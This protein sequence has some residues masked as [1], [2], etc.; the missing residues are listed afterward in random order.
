MGEEPPISGTAGS[1]TI[2]FSGCNLKCVFCQN[3]DVSRNVVGETISV[4]RLVEI[5]HELEEKG[6]HNINLVTPSHYVSKI[7]DAL[8]IYKPSIP[9]VYNTSGYDSLEAID[10]LAGLVDIYLTDLKYC[11]ST[12]SN[13]YSSAGDYFDVATAA[14]KAMYRQVGPLVLDSTGIA[15]RGLIIRHLILPGCTDD[16][17]RVLDWIARNTP[18]ATVSLMSQYTPM[19]RAKEFPEINRTITKLEYKVVLNYLNKLGLDGYMQDMSSVGEST[20]P[21]FNLEGVKKCITK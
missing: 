21:D 5:F 10:S 13:K 1:G 4:D 9:I 8:K 19:Y 11:D 7:R 20:I 18:D 16:S 3:S 14:I 15:K 2:F 17:K 6:V 12:L